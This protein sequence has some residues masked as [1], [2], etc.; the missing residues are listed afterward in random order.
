MKNKQA[1]AAVIFYNGKI[2]AVSRKHDKNDF[3]LCGGKVDPGEDIY[4][5]IVREVYEETGLTILNF[6]PVFKRFDNDCETTTFYVKSWIGFP[7][8]M[9][10]GEVKWVDYP[11]IEKGSFGK[12][13]SDLKKVLIKKKIFKKSGLF[14]SSDKNF[15]LSPF[16]RENLSSKNKYQLNF[17][18]KES[19]FYLTKSFCYPLLLNK[20]HYYII[21]SKEYPMLVLKK[22]DV[23]FD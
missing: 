14:A 5:A 7:R 1:V 6:Y 2:L 20:K 10:K 11:I 23:I 3:G 12:Y 17:E 19:K 22:N 18:H 15:I 9:E 4:Q 21:T 13:N 8:K 16:D